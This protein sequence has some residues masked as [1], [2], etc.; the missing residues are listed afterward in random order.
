MT[1]PDGTS[2]STSSPST[3]SARPSATVRSVERCIDIIDVLSSRRTSMSLSELSRAV[4]TPK[5]T[6]LTIVRTLVHRGLLSF[7]L[8]TKHYQIGLGFSRYMSERPRRVDLISL[9]TPFLEVLARDTLE[10]ATIAMREG[11]KI[12][13][14]CRFVGPQPLQLIVPIGLPR[15][16]HTTAGGKVF[17]AWLPRAERMA[18]VD[19]RP[20]ERITPRTVTDPAL[21]HRRLDACKRDGYS[22][23]RGETQPEL[24]GIAAPILGRDAE[25][26]AT[27]NL[28]G[29][30][31]RLQ[32][33]QTKYVAAVRKAATLIS[34]QIMRVGGE[35]AL[36]SA[37]SVARR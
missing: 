8:E 35:I 24:F 18:Y 36:P 22:V 12:Y 14:V 13:N 26:V 9:A 2:E 32:R 23:N 28:S 30:L 5:S 16:L 27:V 4:D 1:A 25:I 11:D 34:E 31:F 19:S 6:T 15:S 10:T 21:L 33:G 17:L 29:P 37:K 7:D 3:P 20:L